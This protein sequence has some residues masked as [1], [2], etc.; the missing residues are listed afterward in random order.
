MH[1]ER[2]FGNDWF[3]LKAEAFARFFGTPLFLVAQT[4]IV[5]VWILVNVAGMTK[6]DVWLVVSC[7]ESDKRPPA[8]AQRTLSSR[9]LSPDPGGQAHPRLQR[10]RML[11]D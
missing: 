4:I 3:A 6:F 8:T 2:I 9:S 1:L 5:A 7:Y 10:P 11:Q